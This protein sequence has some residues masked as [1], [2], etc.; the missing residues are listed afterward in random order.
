VPVQN[1]APTWITP[2]GNLGII[3]TGEALDGT[4]RVEATDADA[5]YG[6]T[7][8]YTLVDGALPAGVSI[9]PA[10]GVFVGTPT[11]GF[12]VFSFT[13]R[14]TDRAGAATPD[15]LFSLITNARPT[16]D[17]AALTGAVGNLVR[18]QALSIDLYAFVSDADGQTLVLSHEGTLPANMSLVNGVL[19]GTPTLNQTVSWT[20]IVSDG[21]LSA[22]AT[23][24]TR[25]RTNAPPT[26]AA[27]VPPIAVPGRPYT[28]TVPGSDADG[29]ALTYVVQSC[30]LPSGLTLNTATG[31]ISGTPT[32]GQPSSSG[33]SITLV[34]RDVFGATSTPRT[35]TIAVRYAPTWDTAAGDVAVIRPGQTG[36]T[37]DLVARTPDGR[38]ITSFTG[39]TAQD[40]LTGAPQGSASTPRTFRISGN[41]SASAITRTY[42]MKAVSVDGV[43]S[44]PREFRIRVNRDPNLSGSGNFDVAW[45]EPAP[46]TP[47]GAASDPDGDTLVWELVSGTMPEGLSLNTATG[48]LTGTPTLL[49]ETQTLQLRVRDPYNFVSPIITRTVRVLERPVWLSDVALPTLGYGQA[50]EAVVVAYLPN[51]G[52]ANVSYS[53]PLSP[54]GLSTTNSIVANAETPVGP[55]AGRRIRLNT[56]VSSGGPWAFEV[57]ASNGALT[58]VRIFRLAASQPPVAQTPADMT[59]VAGIVGT[60]LT[61]LALVAIDP[62]GGA[63]TYETLDP[64]PTGLSLEPS[65]GQITGTPTSPGVVATRWRARD[66]Q[67]VFSTPRTLVFSIQPAGAGCAPLVRRTPGRIT[68][69][70]PAGCTRLEVLLWGAGGGGAIAPYGSGRANGGSAAFVQGIIDVVPGETLTLSV[71]GL[72]SAGGTVGRGGNAGSTWSTGSASAAGGGATFVQRGTGPASLA[73]LVAVAGGGGGGAAANTG[74]SSGANATNAGGGRNATATSGGVSGGSGGICSSPGGNGAFLAGGNGGSGINPGS[75][76]GNTVYAGGGGGGGLYG[77]AGGDTAKFWHNLQGGG[78]GSSLAP[79]GGTIQQPSGQTPGGADN[80]LR[81][82]AGQGEILSGTTLQSRGD[83]LLILRA[84]P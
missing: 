29:D 15:R 51:S 19:S 2:S 22:Q 3:A 42:T 5:A 76:S 32:D 44:E 74:S 56:P 53:G 50:W 23:V 80:I 54:P 47:L 73:N 72:G 58:A 59:D 69:V 20:L 13:L 71:G 82:N 49:G 14:A 24:S 62:E 28:F 31:V 38:A 79:D 63:L 10:T 61:P 41:V 57:T 84:A 70:V 45:N 4:L 7:L 77:G 39:Y 55:R 17:V 52:G 43:A 12:G 83:G 60:P 48:R 1:T 37:I 8:T 68:Y 81:G 34:A 6:D 26:L 30:S 33:I 67:G 18:N 25:V 65:T 66:P 16:I 21:F 75:C 36:V 40:G 46:L 35:C 11:D 64:L 27:A 9:D 78:G